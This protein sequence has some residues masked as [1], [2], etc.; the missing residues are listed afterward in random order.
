MEAVTLWIAGKKRAR[1]MFRDMGR[2]ISPF[3]YALIFP[4]DEHEHLLV[5][6]LRELGVTAERLVE[7]AGFEDEGEKVVA[8]LRMRDGS[9]E[10]FVVAFIAG[11]DGAHSIVREIL[12]VS[13]EGGIYSPI[14]Y[15]AD[16]KASGPAM[17]GEL[18]AGLDKAE[19]LAIFPLSGV[20]RARF[21]GTVKREAESQRNLTF[22]DISH[23]II[24]SLD[25]K[26]A[27]VN[28]FSTYH[29]HHRVAEHFRKGRV[30]LLGDA[31][32]I[33]CPV[34][35][36]G[37]NTGIGDAVNLAWKLEVVVHG[38][39]S[40]TLLDTYE[41][42]RIAFAR[43]LV[44]TTDRAFRFINRDGAIARFVRV[45]LVPMLMPAFFKL[46]AARRLMFLTLSQTNVN[47]RSS[48]LS[49]GST[50]RVQAGD[51]LL[52][53]RQETGLDNFES[54]RSLKWQAHVYGDT[55][56]EVQRI[57]AQT[58]LSLER[59]PW[60]E[61][62]GRAGLA[63][64]TLYVVRSDGYVGLIA[65]GDPLVALKE[66]QTRFGLDFGRPH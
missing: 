24:N 4:Q 44:A 2:G 54:L 56:V 38:R 64:D 49:T 36:Q 1:I 18:N 47:Y 26:I 12:K 7:L 61:A 11:C 6:Y 39:A 55:S 32:H 43:R 51:R 45:R 17:N 29:V 8:H 10:T 22:D 3:P 13:F 53:V 63:R 15:V 57:S 66:Y 50:A 20:G 21:I 28:W 62:A 40:A 46:R 23:Q 48:M 34:G 31:A 37:M 33:D 19:F 41:T 59:F 60:S 9:E 27:C 58:G 42:E 35:G 5:G 14:F 52:W 30:F 65:C 16:V 25:I